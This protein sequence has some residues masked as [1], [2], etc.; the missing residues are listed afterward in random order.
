MR[1]V[2]LISSLTWMTLFVT[3]KSILF[4]MAYCYGY[5][6]ISIVTAFDN[7]LIRI[8]P[9][10]SVYCPSQVF[11]TNLSLYRAILRS[12]FLVVILLDWIGVP[13]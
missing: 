1:R 6:A 2:I 3:P 13:Q 5:G 9:D 12:L 8:D 10:V 7:Y 4:K 11:S